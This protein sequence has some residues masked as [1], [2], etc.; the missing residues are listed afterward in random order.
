M[1]K[2]FWIII[3]KLHVFIY[4]FFFF[5]YRQLA[6]INE[7]AEEFWELAA[8]PYQPWWPAK[9]L[10]RY[11]SEGFLYRKQNKAP[12]ILY[13]LQRFTN[14]HCLGTIYLY[15]D[16]TLKEFIIHEGHL[17]ENI[18]EIFFQELIRRCKWTN[19]NLLKVFNDVK[20]L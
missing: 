9:V 4:Y 18:K 7:I 2:F 14:V 6:Q 3:K 11:Y 8:N 1:C 15:P 5:I 17:K 16:G 12:Y 19:D 20:N 10:W 13:C